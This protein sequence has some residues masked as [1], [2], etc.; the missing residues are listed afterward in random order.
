MSKL[1]SLFFKKSSLADLARQTPATRDRYVDF[2]RA[3]S[4]CAVVFGH[5]LSSIII[6][7]SGGFKGVN[8]VGI[9]PGMWVITWVLQIMPLFFFVG[10]FSNMVTL[11]A[12]KRR[13]EPIG[14]FFRT[15]VVRLFVPT[16]VFLGIW[17]AILVLPS[18]FFPF[19]RRFAQSAI[20][21]FAPLWFLAVYL[22]VVILS[23]IMRAL[24]RRFHILI[25]VILG[26]L[27]IIVDLVAFGLKVTGVRWVNVALVWL[28]AHQLGF[29]Y[30]DGSLLRLPKWGHALIALGG[31]AGLIVLTNIG[32]Y[33]KS[34]VGT[35]LEKVS[36]MNPPTLCILAL[37]V[38]LVGVAMLVRE[39]IR[40]W[41][42]R[43][44]PWMAVIAANTMIMTIYLW[45]LSAYALAYIVLSP[46]GLGHQTKPNLVF[47]LE[48]PVWIIG[49][50]LIL[51]VL[52]GIFSR[53]ERPGWLKRAQSSARRKDKL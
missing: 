22:V 50:A 30:A 53:F 10:G 36:N 41:L 9:V 19:W 6:R 7:T 47:W 40:R 39:P 16:A 48:R 25:P 51:A 21:M 14:S 35:G 2:L 1:G 4:I 38:W 5:W 11:D 52:V 23:P 33:P 13:G 32:V 42:N 45:H 18:I 29:F 26:V 31:L 8:A 17:L 15:R 37:T 12:F 34:M 3:F 28:C 44:K 43:A 46:L 24:H 20:M 27:A 49:P